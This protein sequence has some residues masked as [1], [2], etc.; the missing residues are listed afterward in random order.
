VLLL[1]E[2][3]YRED[4]MIGSKELRLVGMVVAVALLGLLAQSLGD[5]VEAPAPEAERAGAFLERSVF[6]PPVPDVDGA[7]IEA[8][9]A[10]T[11]VKDV[12]V[13]FEPS[14]LQKDVAPG[15]SVVTESGSDGLT[16]VGFGAP[17]MAGAIGGYTAPAEGATGARCPSS[18]SDVWYFPFGTSDLGYDERLVLYNPFPD[19]AVARV[20]FADTAGEKAKAA[21]DDVAVPAGGIAEVQVNEFIG[22]QPFVSA[23]VEAV[24]GRFVAWRVIF[25]KPENGPRGVSMTLGASRAADT[26]FF[27]EGVLGVGAGQA[28]GI[29]NPTDEE[30]VISVG[31]VTDEKVITPPKELTQIKVARR[32]AETVR[33]DAIP[34]LSDREL[35][36]ASAVVGSTNG[37]PVVVERKIA[38]EIGDLEGISTEIG[39]FA[40]AHTWMVPPPVPH[41][42]N[43][44]V[45]ILNPTNKRAEVQIVLRTRR[46]GA[47]TPKDLSS[48]KIDPGLRIQVPIARFS[49]QSATVAVVRSNRPVVAERSGRSATD[50]G[51]VLG[52]PIDE[53]ILLGGNP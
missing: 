4:R 23:R 27:A 2:A 44:T 20:V 45:S 29:I 5:P 8:V 13:S 39:A 6:C 34:G 48:L 19:E 46:D 33:L 41:P 52:T 38:A 11:N 17:L 36:H 31:L 32:T 43:D 35:S 9:A 26:W 40:P 25:H 22:T 1:V 10:A 51:D 12:A 37:V 24:R 47:K 42:Q 53:E 50:T 30:A 14:G 18:T 28:F 49:S 7:T 21:L 15:S 16:T 3:A